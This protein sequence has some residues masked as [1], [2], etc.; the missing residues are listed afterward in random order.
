MRKS[1]KGTCKNGGGLDAGAPR[2]RGRVWAFLG[3]AGGRGRDEGGPND[4]QGGAK[5][6]GNKGIG[7]RMT[8]NQRILHA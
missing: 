4:I 3:L 1:K 8:V 7:G 6:N 5:V 2:K